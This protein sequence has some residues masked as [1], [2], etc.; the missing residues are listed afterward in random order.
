VSGT[1]TR[2]SSFTHQSARYLV[3]KVAADLRQIQL[4]YAGEPIDDTIGKCVVE[5][6]VL[7]AGGYVQSV[8]YGYVRNGAWV[9][10]VSYDASYDGVTLADDHPGSI[11]PGKD[12]E[13][14]TWYSFLVPSSKW[15][16]L[17]AEQQEEVA[18]RLPFRRTPAT[19]PGTGSSW[20]QYGKTYTKDGGSLRRGLLTSP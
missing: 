5:L 15:Y 18:A 9:L 2:T 14:S 11:P 7:L 3:A 20:W 8:K 19:E 13:G 1:F 4:L 16:G 10:A 12:T 17:T 6:V